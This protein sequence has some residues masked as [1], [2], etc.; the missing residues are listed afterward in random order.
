[1][2]YLFVSI[3]AILIG[4]MVV[5][6]QQNKIQSTTSECSI[7]NRTFSETEIFTSDDLPFC[8]EHIKTYEDS[9]WTQY[10]IATST[11]ENSLDGIKLYEMKV[12]LWRN[13]QIPAVIKSSYEVNGEEIITTLTLFVR[14]VD[15]ETIKKAH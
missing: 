1:M 11:P 15:L 9:H 12:S 7:C 6:A 14:E 8:R 13:H 3:L 10:L 5:T 4:F 2:I